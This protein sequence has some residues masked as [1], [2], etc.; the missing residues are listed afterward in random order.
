MR[1]ST[2]KASGSRGNALWGG[3][4]NSGTR[5][6][7]LWG[8]G[9]RGAALLL[10]ALTAAVLT[11]IS[12]PLAGA[13]NSNPSSNSAYITPGLLSDAQANPRQS[14]DVIVQ[15]VPSKE[16]DW[17]AQSVQ[18]DATSVA[19]QDVS[20]AQNAFQTVQQQFQDAA[21]QA[22]SWKGMLA[23][24]QGDY[25][26]KKSRKASAA[27]LKAALAAVNQDQSAAAAA[28]AQANQL[29]QQL[30]QLQG[31]VGQAQQEASDT[32]SALNNEQQ[33]SSI[34]G[35]H[36]TLTGRQIVHLSHRSGI[37]SIVSNAPVKMQA[38]GPLSENGPGVGGLSNSQIWPWAVGAPIDWLS[39]NSQNAPTIAILD[40]GID[41]TRTAD[42]G[43]RVLGQ[44]NV[45]TLAN[46]SPGDGFGHGTFVASIAAGSAKGHTGVDPYAKLY[47]VDV[48]DDNGMAN[49]ADVVAGCD[50][51]LAHKDQYNIKVANLSLTGTTPASVMYD[52]LDQAVEKLWLN[53][54]VVTAAAGNYNTNGQASGVPYA[55]GNDPFVISA[56]AIDLANGL[57]ANNYTVAP[58]SAF[59]YTLDG[60]SKPELGAPG[61]YMIGAVPPNGGL[62]AQRPAAY[63]GNGY[64][65]LSG[66]SF[67][68]PVIAGA[69]AYLLTQ[70]PNWTPDQVKGAL[71][72]SA[73][74]TPAAVSGSDG[75]GMVNLATARLVSSPPNPNAGLDQ[76][77]TQASDG[78]NAFNAAAW[79]SAAWNNA[80]WNSAAWSSAAWSSAAWS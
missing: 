78:T 67:A 20:D 65:Q 43:N 41:A 37:L 10:A 5:S 74:A 34:A 17:V 22:K 3:K 59:G 29:N 44:V 77:L 21:Y 38:A 8:G 73:Q 1:R 40:S 36:L 31:A 64:M 26:T 61:R 76:Y 16:T 54:I 49:I 28:D 19:Q 15:G 50:W 51:V 63:L 30:P 62:V 55:P 69:A 42:F 72:V 79:N 2:G 56:G 25:S 13:D 23:Q 58:W 48:M 4:T 45:S 12:S 6:N 24:A 39:W 71:M 57:N 32:Q 47:S 27:D 35:V 60:F 53:G 80:A 66:T 9:S 46:N 14:F 11:T 7:G 18:S 33:F 70:H 75:V 68:A 52:P